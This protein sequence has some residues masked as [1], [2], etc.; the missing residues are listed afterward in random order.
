MTIHV[1][2]VGMLQTNCYLL[3]TEAGRA[4][5]IDPG[6]NASGIREALRKE[7]LTLGMIAV[8]HGHWDHIGA[9]PELWEPGVTLCIPKAD[10]DI[11]WNPALTGSGLFSSV[12]GKDLVRPDELYGEGDTLS[13]DEVQLRVMSTPGHTK[14]SSCLLDA[15][16]VLF[17][18]DTLFAGGCGRTDLYGGDGSAMAASLKRLAALPGDWQVLPGHGPETMLS[19]ERIHNPYM[20]TEYDDIF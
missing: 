18:G 3:E 10:E 19:D 17:S 16:G 9:I 2:A 6:A 13:L 7:G 5:V 15:D 12:R 1:L 20:G 14:G 8:T 4:I 11:Y